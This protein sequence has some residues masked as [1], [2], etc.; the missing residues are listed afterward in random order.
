MKTAFRAAALMLL[1]APLTAHLS[2]LTAQ[3]SATIYNDGRVL[4]RRTVSATVPRG[5]SVQHLPLGQLDP[6]SLFSLDDGVSIQGIRYDGGTDDASLL[7]RAVGRTLVFR[8]GTM[9]K[10]TMSAT[11]VSVA[12]FRLRLADGSIVTQSI[13]VPSFPAEAGFLEPSL[14]VTVRSDAARR[15]LRLGYF[16]PG[17]GGWQASYQAV[18][19]GG[20]AWL[21]G[22]AVIGGGQVALDSAEIQLLAGQ[23][24]VA[25]GGGRGPMKA[26][27]GPE[28][29]AEAAIRVPGTVEQKVGE[30]H[31]YTLPGRL[32][33]SPG[34]TTT[35]ALFDPASAPYQKTYVVAGALPWWGGFG[36]DMTTTDVPVQVTYVVKRPR[37]TDLGDRPLPGGIVRMFEPDSAGRL[38]L[39]GETNIDHTPAGEDL[40]LNAGTA[41]DLTARRVQTSWQ[42]GRDS[43][44]SRRFVRTYAIAAYADTLRNAGAADVTVD[45][46]EM[47]SGEW[48]VLSSSVPAE[49]LSSTKVRFRV[50]VPAGGQA[51]LT[52]KVRAVW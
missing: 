22:A 43:S 28:V 15:D 35:A 44:Q 6:G 19:S 11:V 25:S 16:A 29:L 9:L 8:S 50:K 30:F 2:P 33:V 45:V 26:M 36:Q 49:R 3:T 27:N 14:D 46:Y 34:V 5:T 24:S 52:Y 51:L 37:K 21:S 4:V 7:R 1:G 39:I 32:T 40:E 12:P 31:I 17:G 13:G 42:T 18:F 41:F 47:R 38:Q 10:D 20:Q 23:V 48:S